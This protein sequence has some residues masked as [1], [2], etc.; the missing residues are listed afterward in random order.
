MKFDVENFFL[1]LAGFYVP[2]YWWIQTVRKELIKGN[3]TK[4]EAKQMLGVS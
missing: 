1:F 3:L 4:K 2:Y